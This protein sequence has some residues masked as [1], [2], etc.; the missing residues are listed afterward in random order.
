MKPVLK[1]FCVCNKRLKVRYDKLLSSSDFK[2]SPRPYTP[3]WHGMQLASLV[4]VL[5][6]EMWVGPSLFASSVPPCTSIDC[7]LIVYPCVPPLT[8]CS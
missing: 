6:L 5:H 3:L 1:A 4:D 7:L 8:V 2:I